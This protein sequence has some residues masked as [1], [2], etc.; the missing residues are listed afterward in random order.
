M[1][2]WC[3]SVCMRNCKSYV[4]V[5]LLILVVDGDNQGDDGGEGGPE[6]RGRYL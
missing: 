3:V 4:Y 5:M 1:V 6:G 2:V